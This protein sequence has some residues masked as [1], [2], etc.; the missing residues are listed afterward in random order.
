MAS[1]GTYHAG[2]RRHGG[3]RAPARRGVCAMD[4]TALERLRPHEVALLRGGARAA[5]T[6]AV[7]GLYLRGAVEVGRPGTLR[8]SG[9][10]RDVP[11]PLER[12][13]L[14][15]LR[16]PVTPKRLA[17]RPDVR[18]ATAELLAGPA[19]SGLLGPRL[20]RPTRRARRGLRRLR[21][22]H[23]VPASRQG[24]TVHD[25]LLAVA[26]HGEEALAVVVPVFALRAGLTPRARVAYRVMAR[27]RP[28]NDNWWAE[29]LQWGGFDAG[30]DGGDGGGGGGE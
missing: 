23:P 19:G 1:A 10:P 5:V 12:A 9:A 26:L 17:R 29:S 6:V 15:C 2:A 3:R 13:V 16:E 28:R 4:D 30:G 20:L 8:A 7:V 27:R 24:L 18:V 21:R 22:R 25:K 11:D 14:G